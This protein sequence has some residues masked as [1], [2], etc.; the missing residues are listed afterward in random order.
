MRWRFAGTMILL[1]SALALAAASAHATPLDLLDDETPQDPDGPVALITHDVPDDGAT[2]TDNLNRFG[3]TVLDENGQPT[4]HLDAA[5]TLE[6]H[7]TPLFST[8][9]SSGHDYDAIDRYWATLQPGGYNVTVEVPLDGETLTA[10]HQGTAHEADT[11][12]ATLEHDLPTTAQAGEPLPLEY[13]VTTHGGDRIE[14]AH[15]LLEAWDTDDDRRVLQTTTHGHQGPHEAT[16]TLPSEG[17]YALKLTAYHP[18]PTDRTTPFSAFTT[19]HTL[20]VDPGT[21]LLPGIPTREPLENTVETGQSDAPYDLFVTFDPYTSTGPDQK[22]RIGTAIVDTRTRALVEH[23][24]I[25]ARLEAP[26]ATLL[27]ETHEHSYD[28]VAE[29]EAAPPVP[30]D[31]TLEIHA[32]STREDWTGTHQATFSIHPP[33]VPLYAGDYYL[34]LDGD[35]TVDAGTPTDY[36]FR[37]TDEAGEPYDHSEVAITVLDPD[38]QL[39]LA[40]KLHTHDDGLFPFTL[41]LPDPGTYTVHAD[42]FPLMP[43]P[44]LDHHGPTRGDE[45]TY[46]LEA[47]TPESAEPTDTADAPASTSLLPAAALI[48]SILAAAAIARP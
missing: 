37:A 1:A 23:V 26:D 30:G 32:E 45:R 35:R 16:I 33:A 36:T 2:Y 13:D 38:G 39:H 31:Y 22:I 48:A 34:A 47:Q 43:S 12:P 8:A 27:L 5:F 10:T 41:N 4:P 28:G 20:T 44:V 40:G 25:D 46:H 9:P 15:V 6:Q 24:D 19:T 29:I 14:H 18:H 21:P 3:W 42:P 7:G 17:E 11:T